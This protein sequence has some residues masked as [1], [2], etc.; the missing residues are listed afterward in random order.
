MNCWLFI[1]YY[2]INTEGN[3]VF[4]IPI[5]SLNSTIK[6]KANTIAMSTPHEIEYTISF[7]NASVENQKW[8]EMDFS[9]STSLEYA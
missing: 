2:P 7:G 6:V 9:I 4:E 3:S 5:K 8:E 1:K